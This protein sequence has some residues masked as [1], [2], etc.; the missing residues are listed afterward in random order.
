MD[1]FLWKQLKLLITCSPL[2]HWTCL[3]HALWGAHDMD[4]KLKMVRRSVFSRIC[5]GRLIHPWLIWLENQKW[6]RRGPADQS[7]SPF[8]T[9]KFSLFPHALQRDRNVLQYHHSYSF[10]T[11]KISKIPRNY[12]KFDQSLIKVWFKPGEAIAAIAQILP[13]QI[14]PGP[15]DRQGPS[16][17]QVSG[18]RDVFFCG[19]LSHGRPQTKKFMHKVINIDRPSICRFQIWGGTSFGSE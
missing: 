3:K 12:W 7:L 16:P 8:F 1:W 15:K 11:S 17:L 13:L 10:A 4:V 19:A 14:P 6:G 5:Y 2:A 9:V 18:S